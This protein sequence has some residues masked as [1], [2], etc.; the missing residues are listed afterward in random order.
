MNDRVIARPIE[1]KPEPGY[2]DTTAFLSRV[3]E[4]VLCVAL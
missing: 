2:H 3:Y 4:F 1:L